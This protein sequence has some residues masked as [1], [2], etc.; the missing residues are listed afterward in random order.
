MNKSKYEE[1][2]DNIYY[3]ISIVNNTENDVIATFNQQLPSKI[4]GNPADYYM[5]VARFSID[6]STIP[7][8]R[9]PD[10]TDTPY[11]P[12]YVVLEYNG[13]SYSQIVNPPPFA[14]PGPYGLAIYTYTE[15]IECINTA[16]QAAYTGLSGLVILPG[17]SAAPYLVYNTS[18]INSLYA[19]GLYY[20]ES[21]PTPIKIWMNGT[22]F[23]LFLNFPYIF[24]GE[25]MPDKRDFQLRVVNF[26]NTNTS[27]YNATIPANFIK[28]DQEFVNLNRWW[29]SESISFKTLKINVRPEF[30]QG[31]NTSNN[32]SN[33]SSSSSGSGVPFDSIMTDFIPDFSSS[34]QAGWRQRLTYSPQFYRLID[35]L[36]NQSNSIDLS[37]FWKDQQG[38]EFPFYLASTRSA[39]VKLAFIKKSLF[40]N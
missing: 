2:D 13:F 4:L 18:G 37:I 17:G 33:S 34:E 14:T 3:N 7:L 38:R 8:F 22:L 20:S 39:T 19:N 5:A 12:Y 25:G 40:K 28:M 27:T 10:P 32:I 36:G 16:Y 21:L 29:Q 35:L 31:V 11:L 1:K 26:Y 6:G 30:T 9:F 23:G 15:F 24:R